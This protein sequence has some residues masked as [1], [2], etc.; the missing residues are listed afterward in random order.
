MRMVSQDRGC[1]HMENS[2]RYSV[3]FYLRERKAKLGLDIHAYMLKCT[4]PHP[5]QILSGATGCA[6][7]L[8]WVC[9]TWD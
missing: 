3:T 6:I 5:G 8:H 7:E 4:G 1:T 2:R 9:N